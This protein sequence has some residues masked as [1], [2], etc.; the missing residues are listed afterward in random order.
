MKFQMKKWILLAAALAV[1][2]L[3]L[4][5]LDWNVVDENGV[6]VP[7]PP[8]IPTPAPVVLPE[9]V[10]AYVGET[11]DV[12]SNITGQRFENCTLTILGEEGITISGCDFQNSRMIIEDSRDIEISHNIIMDY[13]VH[14]DAAVRIHCVEGLLVD[15]NEVSGN[16][17]GIIIGRCSD[18]V[19]RNNIFE[20]NDQHNAISG[21]DCRGAKIHG[22]LFRF[23]FPHAL[24]IMNRDADPLVQL[25]IHDN[26]FDRN[27]EDAINFE[28]FG[29]SRL[30]TRVYGNRI[31]GTGWAG[32]NVEYNS[33]GANIVI[34]DNYIDDN[35]LLTEEILDEEGR[36]ERLYPAHDH[37]PEAYALGWGHGVKLED[38]SGVIVRGNAIISNAGNGVDIK[39]ARNVTLEENTMALNRIGLSVMGYQESSLHR[40]HSPI[41]PEDAGVS[42]VTV[43]SNRIFDNAEGALYVEEGS[44]LREEE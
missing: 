8:R 29:G 33:W 7:P 43:R 40:E 42:I 1:G 11:I 10:E 37:Q 9:P 28:D 26:L 35:G 3:V 15:H 21:L 2:I 23:N 24:M 44:Q 13:Y 25:L 20:A 31:N 22:N 18:V 14:E 30:V 16:S 6:E 27:I 19:I 5:C 36:P 17:I 4:V 41:S 38:C 12:S 39:N 34:E 32:I